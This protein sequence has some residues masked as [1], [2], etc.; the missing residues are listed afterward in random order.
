MLGLFSHIS[1]IK[2]SLLN[3]AVNPDTEFIS[4]LLRECNHSSALL[5]TKE[6]WWESPRLLIPSKTFFPPVVF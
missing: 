4:L 1:S 6:R 5:K 2:A 3:E